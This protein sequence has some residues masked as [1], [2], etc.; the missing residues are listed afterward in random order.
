[1][2]AF[3]RAIMQACGRASG[4]GMES[5]RTR[6]FYWFFSSLPYAAVM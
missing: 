3:S 5:K 6:S 4:Q 1:M 2:G